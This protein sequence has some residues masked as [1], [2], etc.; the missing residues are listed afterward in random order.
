MMRGPTMAAKNDKPR[1]QDFMPPELARTFGVV[2]GEAAVRPIGIAAI[3]TQLGGGLPHAAMIEIAGTDAAW[4][5]G[6]KVLA[7]HAG[8]CAVVDHDASFFPPGAAALGVDLSRLLIVRESRVREARW[9]LERLARDK[10]IAATVAWMEGLS[11][12]FMRRLQLAAE[13]S[14]QTLLLLSEKPQKA[15]HWCALRLHVQAQPTTGAAR[16]ITVEVTKA[17]GGAMPAPVHIEIDDETGTVSAS[18]VSA[19]GTADP[20]VGTGKA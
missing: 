10:N 3:D 14:G 15:G 9:A 4:W 19:N 1:L 7:A 6:M 18:A 16:R 11:D 20:H 5:L 12:T 2:H 13:S 17:R 8:V